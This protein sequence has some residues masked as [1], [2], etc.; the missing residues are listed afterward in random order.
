MTFSVINAPVGQELQ[1]SDLQNINGG[2]ASLVVGG[3]LIGAGTA[4]IADMLLEKST[5]KGIG[6]HWIDACGKAVEWATS[7]DEGN[8]APTGDGKGCTDRDLPM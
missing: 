6:E 5:G 7:E 8:V 2:G 4:L 3:V 1:L